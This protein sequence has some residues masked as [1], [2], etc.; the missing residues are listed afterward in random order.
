MRYALWVLAVLELVINVS[1]EDG[2]REVRSRRR[3]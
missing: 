3:W 1:L 2:D